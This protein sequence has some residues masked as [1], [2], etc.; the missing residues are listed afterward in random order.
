MKEP[1]KLEEIARGADAILHLAYIHDYSKMDF[2]VATDFEV[3]KA[4]QRAVQGTSKPLI[5][6]SLFFFL[7]F[8]IPSY[9]FALSFSFLVF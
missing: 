2:S 4:F 7:Y 1:A 3:I 8:I 6:L 5:S 9:H